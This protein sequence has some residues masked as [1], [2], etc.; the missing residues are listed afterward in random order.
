MNA[1]I[2]SGLL[3]LALMAIPFPGRS[4]WFPRD[5]PIDWRTLDHHQGSITANEFRKRLKLFSPTKAI[6]PYLLFHGDEKVTVFDDP[7]QTDPVWNLRF[8]APNTA[9]PNQILPRSYLSEVRGAT[10]EHPLNG[11]RI[12]LDPGHIGGEWS[13]IEERHFRY[14]SYEPVREGNLTMETARHLQLLLE[15]AGAEVVFTRHGY[16]PVTAFRPEDFHY[17][18]VELAAEADR[19]FSSRYYRFLSRWYSDF[20]FYRVAEI[21]ARADRVTRLNPDFTLCLHFNA[22]PWG[23][24]GVRLFDV[25]KVVAF[26]H[27]GYLENEVV[28]A[29]QRHSLFRKLLENST[30]MEIEIGKVITDEMKRVWQVPPENY[31]SSGTIFPV[32]ESPYLW[33]RNLVANRMFPGPVIFIEG[34][35]MNDVDAF[36]RIQE[37]DYEG[38][39]TIRGKKV[40]SLTREFARIVADALIAHYRS[41]LPTATAQRDST[42]TGGR[43][44]PETPTESHPPD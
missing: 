40:P 10:F 28:E 43:S 37:G 36:Y 16:H 7:E 3:I 30:Q 15:T 21:H 2:R 41:F 33:S 19:S 18:A 5:R 6:E 8:R 31:L 14:R 11:L 42:A 4:E 20:L 26:I 27:G 1:S 17:E 22:A 23:R 38:I 12:C 25:K 29:N 39:R 24:G 34:L 32:E 9:A 13:T 44:R 35:Y